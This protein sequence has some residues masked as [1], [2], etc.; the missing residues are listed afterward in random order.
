MNFF[1]F[2]RQSGYRTL[3]AFCAFGLCFFF[4]IATQLFFQDSPEQH[5]CGDVCL[6]TST[7]GALGRPHTKGS[8]GVRG[9]YPCRTGGF[10]RDP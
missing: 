6:H 3:R 10:I 7:P 9:K 2:R 5:F 8:R 4:R 1:T